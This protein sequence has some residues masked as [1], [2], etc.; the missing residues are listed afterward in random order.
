M[1]LDRMHFFSWNCATT[2][3]FLAFSLN[4]LNLTEEVL[5]LYKM[6]LNK[7]WT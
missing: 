4:S 6:K 5:A 1:S 7:E 2:K 3:Y